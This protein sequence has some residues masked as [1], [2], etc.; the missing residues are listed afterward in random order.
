VTHRRKGN[1]LI[2]DYTEERVALTIESYLTY[3]SFPCKRFSI[4]PFSQSKE[5]KK[6]ADAIVLDSMKLIPF[7]V[8]F[9]L[10]TAYC[11]ESKAKFISER[12]ELRVNS[13]PFAF[14]FKLRKKAKNATELQHNLLFSLNKAKMPAVYVCSHYLDRTSLNDL[15][16]QRKIF[17]WVLHS[18]GLPKAILDAKISA[19][20]T[21]KEIS[22]TNTANKRSKLKFSYI[23]SLPGH[24]VFP[25]HEWVS[26]H[27][28]KYSFSSLGEEL[29]FHSP[30]SIDTVPI[31]FDQFI[32]DRVFSTYL[33]EEDSP[34]GVITSDQAK[35]ALNDLIRRVGQS[36]V[37]ENNADEKGVA[38]FSNAFSK[39]QDWH[40]KE[41]NI[42]EPQQSGYYRGKWAEWL[43][44]GEYL[45]SVY[46]V[47]QFAMMVYPES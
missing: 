33:N 25:P 29:C 35:S 27:D 18:L 39:W 26:T 41:V 23:P 31:S 21:S 15:F 4:E 37:K 7:Y 47:H 3:I 38:D 13:D 32:K 20:R 28:H 8:Q 43:E 1:K 19:G 46:N 11:S 5:S 9:K 45:R 40:R 42:D 6:G 17:Y 30:H 24:I 36:L 16:H 44:W 12:N 10:P 14:Y 34:R 22:I 2:L